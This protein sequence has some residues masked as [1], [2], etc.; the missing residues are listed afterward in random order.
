MNLSGEP[1]VKFGSLLMNCLDAPPVHC[2]QFASEQIE[3]LAQ[4]RELAKHRFEGGP[5]V[6]AEIDDGLEAGSSVRTAR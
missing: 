1:R 5:V 6:G 4:Q 2:Q 3:P